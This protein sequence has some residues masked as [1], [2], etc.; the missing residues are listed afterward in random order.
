MADFPS[1]TSLIYDVYAEAENTYAI[2]IVAKY[3]ALSSGKISHKLFKH[4][5]ESSGNNRSFVKASLNLN[6]DICID[7]IKVAEKLI[8]LACLESRQI[9]FIDR[10]KMQVLNERI[11][12]PE[13]EVFSPVKNFA[14][15][16]ADGVET[17]KFMFESDFFKLLDRV[18]HMHVLLSTYVES[19]AAYKLRTFE[20]ILHSDI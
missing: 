10:E 3:E 2:Y 4:D 8:V 16:G 18:G 9:V 20:I 19:E 14:K 17:T 6:D 12:L 1:K 7:Q 5:I 15:A 11:T 13:G